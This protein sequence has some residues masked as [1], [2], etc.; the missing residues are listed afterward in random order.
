MLF[1]IF[2]DGFRQ[3]DSS[4]ECKRLEGLNA[5]YFSEKYYGGVYLC[6]NLSRAIEKD[7]YGFFQINGT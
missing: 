7:L 3:V 6:L 2:V 4:N 1:F 5:G